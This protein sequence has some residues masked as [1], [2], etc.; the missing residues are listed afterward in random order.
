MAQIKRIE[1]QQV[2]LLYFLNNDTRYARMRKILLSIA[3]SIL[4]SINLLF[5]QDTDHW[6]TLFY[7][8]SDFKYFTSTEG[9]PDPNWRNTNFNDDAWRSGP[10]GIGYADGDDN[11]I[12]ENTYS[13]AIRKHFVILDKSTITEGVL[14]VD[15]DDAFVAYLNGSEIARSPGL[16]DPFPAADVISTVNHEAVM[17]SGGIP[18]GFLIPGDELIPLLIEGNNV[19]AVQVH[20]SSTN[21]SD[22]SSIITLSV[23]LATNESQYLLTPSWFELPYTYLSSTLPIIMIDTKGASIPNEPKIEASMKIIYNGEGKINKISDT[24]KEYDG[25]IGIEVRGASSAGYP[26]KPWS[27][28]TRD[29]LGMNNNI[30]LLGMPRENDWVLLSHYND[31]SFMRNPISFHLFSKMGHYST[32]TRLVDVVLNGNYEGIY[33]FGEKVKR[34]KWRVDVAEILPH[35][36]S[37]DSL[38]GGY[39]FKTE[40][41]GS[42]NTWQSDYSPYHHPSYST[43]F[44]YYYPKVLFQN[45]AYP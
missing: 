12:I 37:G 41:Y 15:Y 3:L 22:M 8:N 36:N 4:A 27:L 43:H 23:G 24:P 20:N 32:R 7:H 10:G 28:E 13:L 40:Y 19:L 9:I 33:L 1:V 18:N 25:L 45:L 38:T 29:S 5:G 31:K 11:T 21:S 34:D 17:I 26:Q 42:H 6:E 2:I 44:A 39:I 14:H 16:S 35:N 30:P